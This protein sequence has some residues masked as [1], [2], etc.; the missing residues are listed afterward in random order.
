MG[1]SMRETITSPGE[2]EVRQL[3]K[4]LYLGQGS[5]WLQVKKVETDLTG[6]LMLGSYASLRGFYPDYI[7]RLEELVTVEKKEHGLWVTHI[8]PPHYWHLSDAISKFGFM[9]LAH[10]AVKEAVKREVRI[11][12]QYN[13]YSFVFLTKA[14]LDAISLFLNEELRLGMSGGQIDITKKHFFDK[15]E[16]AQGRETLAKQLAGLCNWLS[17]VKQYRMELIHRR[18]AQV[19]GRYVPHSVPPELRV[20][21]LHVPVPPAFISEGEWRKSEEI[22]QFVDEWLMKSEKII[23]VICND[24]LSELSK[25]RGKTSK[26]RQKRKRE[27]IIVNGEVLCPTICFKVSPKRKRKLTNTLNK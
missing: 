24:C 6:T 22:G 15:L 7:K 5:P 14:F 4:F 25:Q 17:F 27:V 2:D 13:F 21:Q 12:C 9:I 1:K 26:L 10:D 8:D 20:E 23:K 3:L 18:P 19:F 11:F 16:Q